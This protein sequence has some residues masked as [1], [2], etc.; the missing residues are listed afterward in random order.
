MILEQNVQSLS[1]PIKSINNKHQYVNILR[2]S[3][4]IGAS[5]LLT[6]ASINK[7]VN[8]IIT[9]DVNNIKQFPDAPSFY[10]DYPYKRP[11]DILKYINDCNISDGDANSVILALEN[12]S[13]YYPMYKLTKAKVIILNNEILNNKSKNILE[14]GK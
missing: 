6:Y 10:Q 13:L 8:A 7:K 11:S 4:T 3:T 12:F 9:N 2:K 5:L 1:E 14:I